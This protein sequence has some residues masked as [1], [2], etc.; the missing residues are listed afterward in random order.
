M[1]AYLSRK[2]NRGN[3]YLCLVY[4]CVKTMNKGSS[5]DSKFTLLKMYLSYLDFDNPFKFKV[6]RYSTLGRTCTL[7]KKTKK[8]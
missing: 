8:V 7:L 2:R 4:N 5:N 6:D 1:Y 3:K